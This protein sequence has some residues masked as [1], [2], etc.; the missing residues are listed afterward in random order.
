MIDEKTKTA[1]NEFGRKLAKILPGFYGKIVFNFYNG[2]CSNL[3]IEHSIKSETL[4][5]R[6][7]K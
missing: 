7:R 2:H 6:N 4:N 3:N 1:L 5:E